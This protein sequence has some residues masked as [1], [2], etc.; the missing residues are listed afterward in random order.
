MWRR[1]C[2]SK[3]TSTI[4]GQAWESRCLRRYRWKVEVF[5]DR[6]LGKCYLQ[7]GGG[8][9]ARGWA[10]LGEGAVTCLSKKKE[11]WDLCAAQRPW[12]CLHL[13]LQRAALLCLIYH[14]LGVTL[15][16]ISGRFCFTP[17]HHDCLSGVCSHRNNLPLPLFLPAN[18]GDMS[19]AGPEIPHS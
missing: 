17:D 5:R 13:E 9:T 4:W 18:S 12:F 7:H 14:C 19:T 8:E 1:K 6:C 10:T 2:A 11:F 3:Q 16:L 15:E